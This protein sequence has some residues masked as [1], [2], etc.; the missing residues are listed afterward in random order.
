METAVS[1]E[2]KKDD[3]SKEEIKKDAPKA[4]I[5]AEKKLE[6]SPEKK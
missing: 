3:S 1:L 6:N 2:P 5:K 4:G